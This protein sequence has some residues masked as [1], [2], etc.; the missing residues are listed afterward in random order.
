MHR[1]TLLFVLAFPVTLAAFLALATTAPAAGTA[2]GEVTFN[3]HCRTCHSMKK[4]D[5]RLGPTLHQIFGAK[6]GAA[7]GYG[8]YSQGLKGSGIVW[9][10]KTLDQFIADPDS[11]ISTNNMK[12]YKGITDPAVR[13][14]IVNFL[15]ANGT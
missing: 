15:K 4:D 1:H 11:V 6:A 3:N 5:N 14:Q 9:D 10:A 2:D 13:E 8:S 12:P 7:P